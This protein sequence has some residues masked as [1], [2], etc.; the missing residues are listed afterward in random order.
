MKYFGLTEVVDVRFIDVTQ[1]GYAITHT[2]SPTYRADID[3]GA[4][5]RHSDATLV[6]RLYREIGQLKVERDFLAE[7][8]G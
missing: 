5:L 7:R 3:A 6:A 8:S 4:D 1:T 2:S